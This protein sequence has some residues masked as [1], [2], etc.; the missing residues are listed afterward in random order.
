MCKTE[1]FLFIYFIF[2]L[3][4]ISHS[5]EVQVPFCV[6][7][8]ERKQRNATS[9]ERRDEEDQ[10]LSSSKRGEVEQR[11]QVGVLVLLPFFVSVFLFVSF[12]LAPTPQTERTLLEQMGR[13]K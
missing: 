6:C 4:E 9:L 12:T 2:Y 13:Q 7:R 11:R 10:K 3:S 1:R 8:R 5:H